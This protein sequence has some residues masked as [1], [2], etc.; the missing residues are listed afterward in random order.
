MKTAE[1]FVFIVILDNI[2]RFLY[3]QQTITVF[4]LDAKLPQ[5]RKVG[6]F[7]LKLPPLSIEQV[8]TIFGGFL[9]AQESAPHTSR[10]FL[11]QT[12]I[13]HF[14]QESFIFLR[15]VVFRDH[16]RHGYVKL[17]MY[18]KIVKGLT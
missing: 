14:S 9:L 3:L 6:I 5:C 4:L 11:L 15:E 18:L 16:N 12:G 17:Y 1:M 7:L 8:P 10:T 2:C 13:R